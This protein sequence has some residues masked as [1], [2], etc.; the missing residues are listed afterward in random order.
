[1]IVPA[2]AAGERLDRWLA[3][4][5]GTSRSVVKRLFDAR[6]VRVDG[7]GSGGS[8]RLAGGETVT[9]NDELAESDFEPLEGE[10]PLVVLHAD[11]DVLVVEKPAGIATHPLRA[12]ERDTLVND[13]VKAY[14]DL[15][16]VGYAKREPGILHRLDRGT[17]GAV[18]VARNAAAFD[19]LRTAL[20][21]GAIEKE[22]T[23]LAAG[24][25]EVARY[26]CFLGPDPKSSKKVRATGSPARGAKSVLT[27][28]LSSESKN[29]LSLVRVSA[30]A[31]YRHQIR[32]H[33]AFLGHPLAGD[34]LYRGPSIDGL[35]RHFLHASAIRLS[36]PQ[37]GARLAIES[38][39]APDLVEVLVRTGFAS[40]PAR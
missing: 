1:L 23:A 18:L 19:R 3:G 2:E 40:L 12:S 33:L 25:V 35:T 38:A 27:N 20:R 24:D 36:H 39:L 26:E 37:T 4:A 5:L 29:D 34:E 32:A 10:R 28:V 22:Y 6:S 7:R 8:A 30:S 21:E 13:L 14:P 11:S 9:V 31:A 16:G 15:R 17:S